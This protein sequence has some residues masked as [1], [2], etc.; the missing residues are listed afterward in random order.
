M[1]KLNQARRTS[2]TQGT[3][4]ALS[5]TVLL[6]ATLL[7]AFRSVPT[8]AAQNEIP[9]L[10]EAVALGSAAIDVHSRVPTVVVTL[11]CV[12]DADFVRIRVSLAQRRGGS[13]SSS[14]Q[15]RETT[16]QAGTRLSVPIVFGPQQGTFRP[17]RAEI[18][19]FAAA[20]VGCCSAD[21]FESIPVTGVFLRPRH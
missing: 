17:G 2:L 3:V 19:G 18:N 9:N 16:C 15:T 10:I 14:F 13:D 12:Q 21:D 6:T 8:V 1:L 4:L 5:A 20:H 7:V 11:T